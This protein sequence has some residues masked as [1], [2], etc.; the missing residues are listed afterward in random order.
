MPISDEVHE[1]QYYGDEGHAVP[2]RDRMSHAHVH[3][4]YHHYDGH[5]DQWSHFRVYMGDGDHDGRDFRGQSGR[6]GR[7]GG[8]ESRGEGACLCLV[9]MVS[10]MAS[11]IS[12][13]LIIIVDQ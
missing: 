12:H 5:E 8:H 1:S 7:R 11:K 3:G 13:S 9:L 4:L 6:G 10:R 2:R